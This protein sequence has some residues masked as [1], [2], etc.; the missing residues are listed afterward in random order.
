MQLACTSSSRKI[1]EEV[2][3]GWSFLA[4]NYRLLLLL[5]LSVYKSCYNNLCIK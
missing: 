2:D 5:F 3:A 1:E 4:K